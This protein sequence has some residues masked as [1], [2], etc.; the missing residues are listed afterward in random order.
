MKT[1]IIT[2]ASRGIGLATCKKFISEGWQVIGTYLNNK[3]PIDSPNLFSVKMDQGDEKS[4]DLAAEKIK[5]KFKK[6]DVLMN[7]A[8]IILD[9][10]D[11]DIDLEKTRKTFEVDVFG[12]T[13]FTNKI[14]PL[15][16]ND[17]HIINVDSEYGSFLF[18]IDGQNSVS[19]RMAKA[20]LNM[21]TR[22]LA[23]KLQ[24]S[25]IIVSSLDPGW[26]K[27]DMGN[28]V[29]TDTEKPDREPEQAANDAFNIVMNVR[30]SGCFWLYGE[31]REW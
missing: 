18:P 1:I 31:K 3:I 14:L 26:T 24:D 21:Y 4:I 11:N 6:I 9:A 8:G 15:I 22:W 7:N 23:Y 30:E 5:E 13:Y 12:L 29:V 2:G 17:G 28:S 19:Y 20:A 27:T 10:H 16:S 25:K